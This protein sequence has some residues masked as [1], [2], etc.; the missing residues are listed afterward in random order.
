MMKRGSQS[1]RQHSKRGRP[2]LNSH[3]PEEGDAKGQDAQGVVLTQGGIPKLVEV[4]DCWLPTIVT[5]TSP[6][7][8]SSSVIPAS[9]SPVF[10]SSYSP[11]VPT[12]STAVMLSLSIPGML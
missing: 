4:L 12:S 8:T 7:V 2:R 5:S 10:V 6:I 11:V 3:H 9:S 1:N